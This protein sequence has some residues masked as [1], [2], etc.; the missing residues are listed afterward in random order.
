MFLH[1]SVILFTGVSGPTHWTD[2]P[3]SHPQADT[4]LPRADTPLG[5]HPP[6]ADTCQAD[7]PPSQ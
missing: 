6:W 5:K 7:T 2:P 4:P 3:T 1:L